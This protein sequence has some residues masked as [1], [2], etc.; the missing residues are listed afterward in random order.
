MAQRRAR[1][2]PW[3]HVNKDR[4]GVDTIAGNQ[5]KNSASYL[6]RSGL[7]GS[8]EDVPACKPHADILRMDPDKTWKIRPVKERFITL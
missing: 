1:L 4:C 8:T 3:Y 7:N 6:A 5:C 2:V